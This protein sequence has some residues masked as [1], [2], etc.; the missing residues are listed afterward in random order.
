MPVGSLFSVA[1]WRRKK[2]RWAAKYAFK[3]LTHCDVAVILSKEVDS[4]R[5]WV[6]VPCLSLGFSEVQRKMQDF[7]FNLHGKNAELC[8]NSVCHS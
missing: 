3:F 4:T 1:L 6:H 5:E 8:I 7:Y 2:I